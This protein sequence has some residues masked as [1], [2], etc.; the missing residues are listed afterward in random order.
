MR[1]RGHLIFPRGQQGFQWHGFGDE[2]ALRHIAANIGQLVP[3]G[4]RLNA[5]GNHLHAHLVGH[6]NDGLAQRIGFGVN[7]EVACERFV[8]FDDLRVDFGQVVERRVAGPKV[9]DGDS[10]SSGVQTEQ[11]V[12]RER[13]VV[14]HH[15][16]G[17]FRNQ[18]HVFEG[19]RPHQAAPML[20]EAFG[21]FQLRG[22]YVERDTE[23][24]AVDLAQDLC[25][26]RDL[27]DHEIP[28]R[29]N[30]TP[31][32]SDE[33]GWWFLGFNTESDKIV[34]RRFGLSPGSCPF[35]FFVSFLS[36]G[37]MPNDQ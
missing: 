16:F 26:L 22:R 31:P 6:G 1:H 18:A 13:V 8:D 32:N 4:L 2:I 28:E 7:N 34:F 15:A 20:Y 17:D 19:R 9:I 5:F 10:Y 27:L 21:A 37:R 29:M 24:V 30:Y 14:D 25:F 36:G 23:I 33:L 3:L 11:I 35:L 12:L